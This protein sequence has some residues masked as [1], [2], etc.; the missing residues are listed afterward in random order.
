ML[1]VRA[2]IQPAAAACHKLFNGRQHTVLQRIHDRFRQLR[3]G[4]VL[5]QCDV[6]VASVLRQCD[7]LRGVECTLAVIGTGGPWEKVGNWTQGEKRG[8]CSGAS[9]SLPLLAQEDP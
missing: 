9:A 3:G 8:R 4:T 6:S 1:R 7:G 2:R 5:R